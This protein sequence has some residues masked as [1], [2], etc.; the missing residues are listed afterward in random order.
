MVFKSIY[1]RDIAPPKEIEFQAIE[2]LQ[3][4]VPIKNNDILKLSHRILIDI[5][6]VYIK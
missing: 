1:L 2:I 6:C 4:K 5:I 3:N